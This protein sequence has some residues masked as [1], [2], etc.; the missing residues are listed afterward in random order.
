MVLSRLTG[1]RAQEEYWKTLNIVGGRKGGVLVQREHFSVVETVLS[2][3]HR[4]Q[5]TSSMF[6]SPNRG[7]S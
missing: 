1:D 5:V 2:A 6:P 4:V 7:R 3:I